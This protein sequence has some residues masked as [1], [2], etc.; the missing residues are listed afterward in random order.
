M[1]LTMNIH[2]L[3]YTM[4]LLWMTLVQGDT[5]NKGRNVEVM[6]RIFP[7]HIFHLTLVCDLDLRHTDLN[8]IHDTA[9]GYGRQLYQI[10]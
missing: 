9:S 8:Y 2:V 6:L 4:V 10:I 7:Q 3:T 1:I 5:K